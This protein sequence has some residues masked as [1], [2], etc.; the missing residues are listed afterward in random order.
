MRVERLSVP[1]PIDAL[2]HVN[3]YLLIDDDGTAIL[4]DPGMYWPE[5]LSSLGRSMNAAG[6]RVCELRAIVITHFHVDHATA[7]PLI[8]SL[9]PTP[10]YMGERDL[11]T[12][13]AGF[14]SYFSGVLE[15]YAQYGVPAEELQ[16]IRAVHPVPRLARAYDEL[17]ASDLR[18]L[19]EGDTIN[20]A[21]LS[22]TIIDV[23]G[24]TPGHVALLVEGGGRAIVG[25][26]LLNDITP[27]VILDDISRDP[28][29]EYLRTLRKIQALGTTTALPGHR[30]YVTDP[31]GR[32][33]EVI[34][35][36]GR[37]LEEMKGIL[38]GGP[39]TLY[40]VAKRTRW[41]TRGRT[42]SEM[43]P[44][45]RYFAIGEALAH[46]RRLVNVGQ[47]EEITTGAGVA[48]RLSR[49]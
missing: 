40:E 27:H 6:V 33:A 28:L 11:R 8:A 19:R 22:V 3:S 32:A 29:G 45:E 44:Y 13:R 34:A 30:D 39:A 49:P 24:H 31:V 25:D 23:P 7:A 16:A 41:R 12:V 37:R 48:F 21:G 9:C 26:S 20:L 5:G 1:I 47:A 15:L 36:H 17:A 14:E 2:G 38:A 18:P 4:V 10:I 42:W 43:S 35:H 46:L